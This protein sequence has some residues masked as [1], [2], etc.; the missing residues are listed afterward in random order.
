VVD[1]ENRSG[2]TPLMAAARHGNI[3]IIQ[4]LLA[5]GANPAKTDFTG[6]DAIGWAAESHRPAVITA[7]RRGVAKK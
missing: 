6:R 5:H 4:A 7:L 1:A 3:E 2:Q